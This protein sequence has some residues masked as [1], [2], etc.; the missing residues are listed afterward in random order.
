MAMKEGL[1]MF[2]CCRLPGL[3]DV[4][5]MTLSVDKERP[6][7]LLLVSTPDRLWDNTLSRP[8]GA[9]RLSEEAIRVKP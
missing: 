8:V 1:D 4:N 5:D 7:E 6:S 9:A 3:P 2:S